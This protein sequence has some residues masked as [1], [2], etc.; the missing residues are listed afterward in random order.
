MD[1]IKDIQKTE[2]LSRF[3][4]TQTVRVNPFGANRAADRA[5][6]R[7]ERIAAGIHLLTNHIDSKESLRN[8]VRNQSTALLAAALTVRYEM[9]STH[10]GP[11]IEM[12]GVIRHLI[13]LVRLLAI[14]GFASTQ[15]VAAIVEALDELG[16]F[17]QVSQRTHFSES[18]VIHRDDLLDTATMPVRQT[19]ATKDIKDGSI[20]GHSD[21]T[22]DTV[23]EVVKDVQS[24]RQSS[25]RTNSILEVLRSEGSLSIKDICSQLPEYSE[26]M[27]QRELLALVEG[28]RVSKVGLKRWSR[29]SI[30]E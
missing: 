20:K 7:S 2:S 25:V 12:L 10:S 3:L 13:S 27:I 11:V 14:S 17:V 8:S 21:D 30:A 6:R 18:I 5:Y 16:N 15:N 28:K 1:D 9:R 23:G 29:Y 19:G 22:K 26:K 4:D 24:N